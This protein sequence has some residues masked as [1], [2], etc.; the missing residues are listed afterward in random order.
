ME[1]IVILETI[2]HG[3]FGGIS[4]ILMGIFSY[5]SDITTVEERT[6]RVGI[7]NMCFLLSISFGSSLSG[8]VLK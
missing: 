2:F 1:T 4:I 3:T 7:V 5:I 6:V 8:L